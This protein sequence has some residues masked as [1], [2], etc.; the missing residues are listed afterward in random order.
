MKNNKD[1]E[2]FIHFFFLF[3]KW[4]TENC[5]NL[6]YGKQNNGGRFFKTI[7]INEEKEFKY[8]YKLS[9]MKII[10]LMMRFIHYYDICAN[11]IIKKMY[12]QNSSTFIFLK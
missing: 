2:N 9:F 8:S 1:E 6:G 3:C 4:F 7:W 12:E 10:S 11:H 5:E